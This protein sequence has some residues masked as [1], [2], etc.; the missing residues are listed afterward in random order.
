MMEK[1]ESL[2]HVLDNP[3]I[4]RVAQPLSQAVRGAYEAGGPAAQLAKNAIPECG[5]PR[6][7]RWAWGSRVP[8]AQR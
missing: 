5:G 2:M 6:H 4:D 8:R 3:A 7:S 1:S